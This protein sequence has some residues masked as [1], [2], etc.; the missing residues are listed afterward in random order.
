M[1]RYSALL[2]GVAFIAACEDVARSPS[3]AETSATPQTQLAGYAVVAAGARLRT[4]ARDDADALVT[5]R[6]EAGT[7]R[8]Y[9]VRVYG[10]SG[11]FVEVENATK[12]ESDSHCSSTFAPITNFRLRFYVKREELLTV[13]VKPTVTESEDGTRVRVATA[14]LATVRLATGA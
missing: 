7:P 13:T 5:P 3:P 12:K 14:R 6:F 10:Q 11:D 8:G 2:A 9:L 4:G 1:N